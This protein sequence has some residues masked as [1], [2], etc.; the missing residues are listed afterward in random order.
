[1]LWPQKQ[2]HI[3]DGNC[4]GPALADKPHCCVGFA[5]NVSSPI[6]Q[7]FTT[8]IAAS[9]VAG[10]ASANAFVQV[11]AQ[12]ISANGC[13]PPIAATLARAVASLTSVLQKC[14]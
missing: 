12:A 11:I 9:F 7:L 1:M 2:V 6:N 3:L 14:S 4:C 10:G 8:A 13:T 5:E